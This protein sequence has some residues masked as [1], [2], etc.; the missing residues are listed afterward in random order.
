MAQQVKVI[1]IDA[2][3][4]F[5]FSQHRGRWYWAL[6]GTNI[7]AMNLGYPGTRKP[8]GVRRQ[9]GKIA[10]Y[11][12]A[13]AE[14]PSVSTEAHKPKVRSLKRRLEEWCEQPVVVEV[15]AAV[16]AAPENC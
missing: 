10:R 13:L 1:T 8:R 12:L 4:R 11:L 5:S 3:P 9:A 7:H 15:R 6:A 16:R 14:P 2:E